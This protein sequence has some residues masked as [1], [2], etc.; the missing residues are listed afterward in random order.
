MSYTSLWSKIQEELKN[1]NLLFRIECENASYLRIGGY[2]ARPY[3]ITLGIHEGIRPSKIKGYLRWWS[4]VLEL[5]VNPDL[6]DYKMADKKVGKYL[7]SE[8]KK[9]GQSKFFINVRYEV[10]DEAKRFGE[11]IEKLISD[12]TNALIRFKENFEKSDFFKEN[13]INIEIDFNPARLSIKFNSKKKNDIQ[14]LKEKLIEYTK[15]E[16]VKLSNNN[17]DVKEKEKRESKNDVKEKKKRESKDALKVDLK[18][19]S[20]IYAP[21]VN[22]IEISRINL[23]LMQRRGEKTEDYIRRLKEELQLF[24]PYTVKIIIEVFISPTFT[25]TKTI[26]RTNIN[27]NTSKKDHIKRII[28]EIGIDILKSVLAGLILAL[29]VTGLS[30][31]S[32]RGFAGVKIVSI[33]VSE[34]LKDS[35]GDG[36]NIINDLLEAKNKK[37]L[38][39]CI[40]NL[41]AWLGTQKYSNIPEV[42]ALDSNYKFFKFKVFEI[43][44]NKKNDLEILKIIN[45]SVMKSTWKEID[46]KRQDFPGSEYHT[47]ILGLPRSQRGT[48]YIVKINNKEDLSF[49]RKS[50]IGIN[51][52]ENKH[53]KFII[54]HGFISNDWPVFKQ[55]DNKKFRLVHSSK[56]HSSKVSDVLDIL[57]VKSNEDAVREAFNNAFCYVKEYVGEK[58]QELTES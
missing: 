51:I 29:L 7:G 40:E 52:F 16:I 46:K 15:N 4:R 45:K 55:V 42:P 30:A 31:F 23:I 56:V 44:K 22:L 43:L 13:N 14:N 18:L 12:Y 58:L 19:N 33:S 36:Y 48:G 38:N 11:E 49:R 53:R 10:K 25:P 17:I 27:N 3:S 47:W 34:E 9:F 21:L 20:N 41:I 8:E 5:S 26:N 37:D 50:A 28:T 2:N 54:I 39:K 1:R 24:P 6:M 57:G 35:L 32:S